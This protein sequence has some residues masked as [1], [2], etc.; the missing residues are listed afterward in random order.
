MWKSTDVALIDVGATSYPSVPF[1]PSERYPEYPFGDGALATQD[2]PVYRGVRDL[3]LHLG[4]D[5]ESVDP[6]DPVTSQ[7]DNLTL[8]YP[9]ILRKLPGGTSDFHPLLQTSEESQDLDVGEVQIPDPQIPQKLLAG[10][11]PGPPRRNARGWTGDYSHS[12]HL[13]VHPVASTP[14]RKPE[15]APEQRGRLFHDLI[16]KGDGR[17]GVGVLAVRL[18]LAEV[19]DA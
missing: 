12:D 18:S 15:S 16:E 9:G 7:I 3:L 13:H 4:L 10:F 8:A 2:N 5:K 11:V 1:H 19:L 17:C 14:P 6:E